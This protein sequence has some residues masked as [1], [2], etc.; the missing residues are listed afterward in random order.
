M[1]AGLLYTPKGVWSKVV[2]TDPPQPPLQR[3]TITHI[4]LNNP[5][6]L[7]AQ[8]FRSLPIGVGVDKNLSLILEKF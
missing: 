7:T 5:E 3:L 8:A 2:G 4:I 1:P 6:S